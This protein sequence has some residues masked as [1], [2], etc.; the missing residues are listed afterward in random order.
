MLKS[1]TSSSLEIRHSSFQKGGPPPPERTGVG[2]PFG[3]L[4]RCLA[5]MTLVDYD[6]VTA[7]V[8]PEAQQCGFAFSL[9]R[10][11]D[12]FFRV[13]NRLA[14][15]LLNHVTRSQT[16]FGSP[17]VRSDFGHYCSLYIAWQ[18]KLLPCTPVQIA[19]C[20][21]VQCAG[22]LIFALGIT[23][24]QPFGA[25]QFAHG[26]INGFGGT[27][28]GDFR[29]NLLTRLQAGHLKLQMAAV[30]DF[31]SI[32]LGNHV[33]SLKTSPLCRTVR[34]HI[35]NQSAGTFLHLKLFR[36]R[37]CQIL[38]HYTEETACDMTVLDKSLHHVAGQIDGYGKS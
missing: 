10:Q 8:A 14:I 9:F 30:S 26:H 18:I 1:P 33:A 19:H 24:G 22:I 25:R 28:P 15:D 12:G 13:A 34:G 32:K 29:L 27:I 11:L 35:P 3:F 31:L 20:Y 7:T 21:T 6:K 37:R 4:R 5:S 2:G 23:L 38:D 17:G 16:C 36:Q